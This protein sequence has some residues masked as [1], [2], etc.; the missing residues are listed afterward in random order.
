[1]QALLVLSDG[2][3][4]RGKS[5][6]ARNP[7]AGEL[8]FNTGMVGY[9]ES[10]TDRTHTSTSLTCTRHSL[11]HLSLPVIP[12]A[13]YRGQILTCTYP[14]VG[15]YGVPNPAVLDDLGLPKFFESNRIQAR[16]N[17]PVATSRQPLM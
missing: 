2:T 7:T 16:P 11:T 1:M 13:S 3:I 12:T 17:R 9:P 4:F 5:F 6:G 15:N 8:V 14:L 10:M